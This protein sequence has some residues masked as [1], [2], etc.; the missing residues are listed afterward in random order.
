MFSLQVTESWVMYFT[1][2]VLSQGVSGATVTGTV[3]FGSAVKSS[4]G[5]T[6]SKA[7]SSTVTASEPA[8]RRVAQVSS[9][10]RPAGMQPLSG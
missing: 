9:A 10:D 3:K 8:A 1:V 5:V 2:I 4:S 6:A 7:P